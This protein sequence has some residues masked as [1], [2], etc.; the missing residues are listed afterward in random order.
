MAL[1]SHITVYYKDQLI[2]GTEPSLLSSNSLASAIGQKT[3][4]VQDNTAPIGTV[5]NNVIYPKPGG[6]A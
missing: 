3:G 2:Y 1:N 6:C 4:I 5:Q